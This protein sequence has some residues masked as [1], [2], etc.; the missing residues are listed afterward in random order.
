MPNRSYKI[1]MLLPDLVAAHAEQ[2]IT[3]TAR[4][5]PAAIKLACEEISQRAHVLGKH[6]RAGRIQFSLLETSIAP[7]DGAKPLEDPG[8]RQ[9]SL[10]DY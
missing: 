7:A 5:W 4:N 1:T 10:F 9:E 2:E 6:V 8:A 3:V